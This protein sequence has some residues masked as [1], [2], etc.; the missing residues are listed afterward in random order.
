MIYKLFVCC[1]EEANK[2]KSQK[3]RV[4]RDVEKA[5]HVPIQYRNLNCKIPTL[6]VILVVILLGSLFTLFR[7]PVV[8][9]AD[10]PSHSGC[11]LLLIALVNAIFVCF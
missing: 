1:R 6:K 3:N 7:S 5:L 4:F 11:V 8:H 10:H 9:I 2:R